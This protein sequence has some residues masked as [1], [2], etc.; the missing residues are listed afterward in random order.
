MKK[1]LHE[2]KTGIRWDFASALEDFVFADEITLL[3][4]KLD[5]LQEKTV[6]LEE[7]VIKVGF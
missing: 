1:T 6:L 4:S 2:K 7:N 5:D 3:P